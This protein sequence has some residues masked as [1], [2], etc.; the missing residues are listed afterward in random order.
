MPGPTTVLVSK[1]DGDKSRSDPQGLRLAVMNISQTLEQL[2]ESLES[3]AKKYGVEE[4]YKALLAKYEKEQAKFA[5]SLTELSTVLSTFVKEYVTLGSDK[6]QTI[7]SIFKESEM[8][9]NKLDE[10]QKAV[11]SYIFLVY[12]PNIEENSVISG[13]RG[14]SE[15]SRRIFRDRGWH[16]NGGFQASNRKPLENNGG[17]SKDNEEF[18]DS[19]E[20]EPRNIAES[21]SISG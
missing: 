21:V 2:E 14:F 9:F 4:K 11:V 18:Q 3:W 8:L 6:K 16:S 17:F 7:E 13:I 15:G 19:D 5:Q 12:S 1:S 10:K 20:M